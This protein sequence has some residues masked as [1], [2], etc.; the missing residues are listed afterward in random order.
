M[1]LSK[2]AVH[3][4]TYPIGARQKTVIAST[5]TKT[6]RYNGC[7]KATLIHAQHPND[8]RPDLPANRV[9]DTSV[10]RC[11]LFRIFQFFVVMNFY[12]RKTPTE[13]FMSCTSLISAYRRE[14][15]ISDF[16]RLV[17]SHLSSLTRRFSLSLDF[18][19]R[20]TLAFSGRL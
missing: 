3:T 4:A 12:Y 16:C 20:L 14:S 7:N 5:T 13:V 18:A 2:D 8:P 9:Y 1:S 11:R 15:W 6:K 10:L 17:F 19:C